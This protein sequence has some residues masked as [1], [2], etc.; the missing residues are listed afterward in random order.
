MII[1]Q[2]DGLVKTKEL[3]SLIDELEKKSLEAERM[4]RELEALK[5]EIGGS[6][7]RVADQI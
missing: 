7:Q 5:T 2:N 3:K 1:F 4:R 6:K